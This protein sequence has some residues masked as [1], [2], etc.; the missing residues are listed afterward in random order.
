MTRPPGDDVGCTGVRVGLADGGELRAVAVR[1]A[2]GASIAVAVRVGVRAGVAVA[3]KVG[4]VIAIDSTPMTTGTSDSA[5]T[6]ANA[7][8]AGMDRA[9]PTCHVCDP[10]VGCSICN[11]PG[12][13]EYLTFVHIP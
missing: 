11:A 7:P 13:S 6:S 9:Q 8:E 1:V 4:E 5:E 3:V 12:I 10:Y 2:V